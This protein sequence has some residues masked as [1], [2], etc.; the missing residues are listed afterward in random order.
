MAF[1]QLS[2]G[3]SIHN[4]NIFKTVLVSVM[5]LFIYIMPIQ[6]SFALEP[7][8]KLVVSKI[9]E[10][11]K[12]NNRIAIVNMVSYPLLRQAPIAPINNQNELLKR[13]DEVFDRT[14]LNTIIRSNIHTDWDNIGWQGVI[15]ND[16]IVALDPDG[17]ITDI[18]Y[19]SSFEQ[20]LL[21][22][23]HSERMV[24]RDP[25]GRRALHR[26]VTDYNKALVE[27]TTERFHIRIDEVGQGQ[28]RYASWPVTKHLSEKPDLV[29]I[30]G[31]MLRGSG[32]NQRFVFN[33]GTYRYQ[34]NINSMGADA[35]PTGSL[36]VYNG[37][38]WV[39][40]VATRVIRR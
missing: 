31:K 11:F 10:A 21:N 30:N 16:G 3:F 27:L 39:R 9:V 23:L 14:L 37:Q 35:L 2:K 6:N 4:K 7:Q 32:R 13:Y 19:L 5:M 8:Q 22:K 18:N 38:T 1:I 25:K 28:L 20:A 36:E 17:N 26:S 15:L 40:E 24:K 33:N 12:Q 34:L 29:L